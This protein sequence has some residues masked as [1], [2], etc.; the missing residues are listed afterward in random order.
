[1]VVQNDSEIGEDSSTNAS[2]GETNVGPCRALDA[3]TSTSDSC[4][5]G[6]SSRNSAAKGDGSEVNDLRAETKEFS[7]GGGH[8]GRHVVPDNIVKATRSIGDI[9]AED[10]ISGSKVASGADGRSDNSVSSSNDVGHGDSSRVGRYLNKC[11]RGSEG[12]PSDTDGSGTVQLE[13]LI[14]RCR[15][16]NVLEVHSA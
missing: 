8:G 13:D 1:M 12:R 2:H 11:L 9:A 3:G 16:L 14:G 15:Q 6:E 10:A 4:S 5:V 7:S